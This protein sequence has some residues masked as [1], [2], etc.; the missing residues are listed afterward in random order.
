M[1]GSFK[2]DKLIPSKPNVRKLDFNKDLVTT[3]YRCDTIQDQE[4]DFSV[5][6]TNDDASPLKDTIRPRGKK[7]MADAP[8]LALVDEA[9][10]SAPEAPQDADETPAPANGTQGTTQ[11]TAAPSAPFA[12][13]DTA[14]NGDAPPGDEGADPRAAADAAES[15]LRLLWVRVSRGLYALTLLGILACVGVAIWHLATQGDAKYVVAWASA[16]FFVA[17]AVTLAAH[18]IHM[19]VVFY[20]HPLQRFYVRVL[21]M[22]P[23]YAVESWLALRFVAQR[24]YLEVVIII[25]IIIIRANNNNK[26]K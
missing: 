3:N 4:E 22:V 10:P 17:V 5:D 24:A 19:H 18:A 1:P 26:I 15:E 21:W 9:S 2:K 14:S 23:I 11:P 6:R 16:A 7:T 20:R 12:E 8:Q 13:R 25:I